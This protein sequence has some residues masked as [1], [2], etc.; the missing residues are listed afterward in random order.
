M[1]IY[2]GTCRLCDVGFKTNIIDR[3]GNTLH[4]GDI[5]VIWNKDDCYGLSVVT[6]DQWQSYSDGSHVEKK[7]DVEFFVMGIKKVDLANDEDWW[8]QRV[9]SFERVIDGERW[10][11]QEFSYYKDSPQ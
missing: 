11:D 5:V 4:T 7:E 2:S 1:R 6:G 8:V 10:Q 3:S 9:K